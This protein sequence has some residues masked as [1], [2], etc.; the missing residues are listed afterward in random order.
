MDDCDEWVTTGCPSSDTFKNRLMDASL[1]SEAP[2]S[3]KL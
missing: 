3:H 1:S 2:W